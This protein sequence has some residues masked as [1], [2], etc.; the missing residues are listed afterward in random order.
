MFPGTATSLPGRPPHNKRV[1]CI[2]TTMNTDLVARGAMLGA[3]AANASPYTKALQ[4]AQ[5]AGSF[6]W[7]NRDEIA[8][9]AKAM[10]RKRK[11]AKYSG[12]AKKKMR[13]F[14]AQSI[15]FPAD[16]RGSS[17]TNQVAQANVQS[18]AT[19]TL[20][21]EPTLFNNIAQ[22]SGLNAINQ[23][24]RRTIYAGGLKLC[25]EVLNGNPTVPMYFNVAI[26]NNKQG[27]GNLENDFFRNQGLNA[28]REIDFSSSLSSNELHCLP[29]NTDKYNVLWHGRY[30]LGPGSSAENTGFGGIACMP[31]FKSI[32]AYVPIKRNIRYNNGGFAQDSDVCM[33]YWAAPFAGSS[34]VEPAT[35]I[36]VG[37]RITA[38]FREPKP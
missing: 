13:N 11:P 33:V 26:L 36:Q 27:P 28:N 29:V 4:A 12:Q 22:A 37:Y 2:V 30:L 20:H 1:L 3:Y 6:A 19:K 38:Y 32:M 14:T 35:E 16:I 21:E 5:S 34:A 31:S 7:Q 25:M 9:L 18:R 17:K 10:R 23:R 8:K 15:G 24:Q